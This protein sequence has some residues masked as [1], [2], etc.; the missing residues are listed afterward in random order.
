ML[1]LI[2]RKFWLIIIQI[3]VGPIKLLYCYLNEICFEFPIWNPKL[4]NPRIGNRSAHSGASHLSFVN[5]AS[6][7]SPR[8]W[9]F[10]FCYFD[11]FLLRHSRFPSRRRT[12]S[13]WLKEFC[14]AAVVAFHCFGSYS[15][16]LPPW[17][18]KLSSIYPCSR[19]RQF[20]GGLWWRLCSDGSFTQHL[21]LATSL[22]V[23]FALLVMRQRRGGHN[24]GHSWLTA[25][26]R[27]HA[28]GSLRWC[29]HGGLHSVL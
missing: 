17:L 27:S 13:R 15:C 14:V 1:S 22:G 16:S 23:R 4:M 26:C 11:G 12:G 29:S 9:L 21:W 5:I 28:S 7:P 20:C 3:K 24:K 6:S 2:E 19:R 10:T 8:L 18:R 25:R